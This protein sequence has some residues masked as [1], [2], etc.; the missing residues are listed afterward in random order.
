VGQKRKCLCAD[1]S[2]RY[3]P[4]RVSNPENLALGYFNETTGNSTF[5]PSTVDTVNHKVTS[6]VTHFSIY[7]TYDQ[8]QYHAL[9]AA[10]QNE[11]GYID[12]RPVDNWTIHDTNLG[13]AS[14]IWFGNSLQYPP[15]N[16]TI[17]ASGNYNNAYLGF[18]DWQTGSKQADQNYGTLG[19]QIDFNNPYG[20]SEKP[21]STL[22]VSDDVLK[23]THAGGR[24]GVRNTGPMSGSSVGD[25]TYKI[26]YGHGPV[27]RD[28]E[29]DYDTELKNAAFNATTTGYDLAVTAYQAVAGC[30]LGQ[31]GQKGGYLD[32][33]HSAIPGYSSVMN[34]EIAE[35]PAYLVGHG[36][37]AIA[38]S[39]V[40]R[41][42]DFTADGVRGDGGI[43]RTEI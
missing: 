16:Y 22:V 40:T 4:G 24:I 27:F 11:M 8:V 43:H 36:A 28:D 18:G 39:E 33:V 20:S 10:A 7:G 1:V 34:D 3:D 17:F 5:V 26:Y 32:S 42:R 25:L 2:I 35:S 30:V 12:I 6:R 21:V 37:C 19:M 31:A 14:T 38:F 23:I 41:G 15:G 13:S 29:L 9:P